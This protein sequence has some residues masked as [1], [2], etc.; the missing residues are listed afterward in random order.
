MTI[1]EIQY[2]AKN[3]FLYFSYWLIIQWDKNI[4]RAKKIKK[5]KQKKKNKKKTKKNKTKQKRKKKFTVH[6]ILDTKN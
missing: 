6:K 4:T 1:N 2:C 3:I 5:T